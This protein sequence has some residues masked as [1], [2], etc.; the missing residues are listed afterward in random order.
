MVKRGYGIPAPHG[1][2]VAVAV[3]ALITVLSMVGTVALFWLDRPKEEPV[4]S[5]VSAP[6]RV[7]PQEIVSKVA[8]DV[9]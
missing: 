4:A 5:P 2:R 9:Q 3:L 8:I 6:L 7:G 1:I